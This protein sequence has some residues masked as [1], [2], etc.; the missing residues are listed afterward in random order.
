MAF[1]LTFYEEMDRIEEFIRIAHDFEFENSL[2]EA[3][4]LLQ[5]KLN[6]HR[7]VKEAESLRKK[8]MKKYP[9]YSKL[10]S[11]I[12]KVIDESSQADYYITESYIV[13][14]NFNEQEIRFSKHYTGSSDYS[15]DSPN[16][17][18]TINDEEFIIREDG[19]LITEIDDSEE[20]LRKLSACLDVPMEHTMKFIFR[21]VRI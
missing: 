7:S 15:G 17:Y 1:L 11:T 6:E 19:T 14:A 2:E 9:E 5:E 18:V 20:E 21:V 12:Y 3:I 10:I 8:L 16:V 13:H 4:K